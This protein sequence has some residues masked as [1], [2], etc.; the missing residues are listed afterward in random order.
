MSMAFVYY[1]EQKI[2]L[3][4]PSPLPLVI[5]TA[6]RPGKIETKTK[7]MKIKT[8]KLT[9]K[10]QEEHSTKNIFLRK[11]V[12]NVSSRNVE[13]NLLPCIGFVG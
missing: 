8:N 2:V 12:E 10:N 1:N 5:P 6:N 7:E 11:N 4:T 9:K 13:T 3:I